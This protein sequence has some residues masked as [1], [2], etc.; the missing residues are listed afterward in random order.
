M[1]SQGNGLDWD[2]W[3]HT[4]QQRPYLKKKRTNTWKETMKHHWECDPCP[5][6]AS[7]NKCPTIASE[8]TW[9]W[10]VANS[11]T[12]WLWFWH[13]Y[14]ACNQGP[15]YRTL[16]SH[17]WWM[18][19]ENYWPFLAQYWKKKNTKPKPKWLVLFKNPHWVLLNYALYLLSSRGTLFSFNISML[20][21]KAH[22]LFL[23]TEKSL[24]SECVF[25]NHFVKVDFH[26]SQLNHSI[27]V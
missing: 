14:L 20:F 10:T 24:L 18:W 7:E 19:K 3:D 2:I 22:F 4:E 1:L 27:E 5:I 17:N 6:S 8:G 15:H 16:V 23:I 26:G 12:S 25:S 11:H 21:L 13:N 9:W